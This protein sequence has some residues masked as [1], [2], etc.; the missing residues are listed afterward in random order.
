MTKK[1][2]RQLRKDVNY[3]PA[4]PREY[5]IVNK[6]KKLKGIINGQAV[7]KQGTVELSDSCSRSL[8]QE[9]KK[10]YEENK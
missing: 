8:Y 2:A 6:S 3:H 7:F 1:V 4:D 5:R 9:L 10:E